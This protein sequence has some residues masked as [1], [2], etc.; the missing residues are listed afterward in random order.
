M[1]CAVCEVELTTADAG[2]L[3]R[4]DAGPVHR[5]CF[6]GP[7]PPPAKASDFLSEDEV[8]TPEMIEEEEE[9]R[10]GHGDVP[11]PWDAYPEAMLRALGAFPCT[12]FSVAGRRPDAI[13]WDD[14]RVLAGEPLTEAGYRATE[15]FD[16]E[17]PEE[18]GPR[19]PE[20][21]DP[22]DEP[23][24]CFTCRGRSML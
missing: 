11:L 2:D 14:A 24:R 23:G 10:R 4:T 9:A 19:C 6:E 12:S 3:V 7:V 18:S 22:V 16:D 20:C 8:W 21:G 17:R 1:K 15:G 13:L 5:E